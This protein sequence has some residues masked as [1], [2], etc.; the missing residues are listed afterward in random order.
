MIGHWIGA[1]FLLLLGLLGLWQA[2]SLPMG[3]ARNP[4][5]GLF[6]FWISLTL[7]GLAALAMLSLSGARL[8][9]PA[10][11]EWPVRSAWLRIVVSVA[12]FS[13]YAVT[14]EQLGYV[15]SA[16]LLI[17]AFA[18]VVFQRSWMAS[19]LL[20]VVAVLTSYGLFVWLLGVRLPAPGW[21]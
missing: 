13:G 2:H 15:L 20:A 18:K 14:L 12:L 16:G 8:Q 9:R 11:I 1:G 19:G 21:W 7:C 6:P 5:S 17:A 4:G 10:P 3:S